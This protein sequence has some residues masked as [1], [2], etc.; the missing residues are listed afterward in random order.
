MS[1]LRNYPNI[2]T[3]RL[4]NCKGIRFETR[5]KHKG[6]PFPIKVTNNL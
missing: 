1:K 3:V 6:F 4:G 2:R 5:P